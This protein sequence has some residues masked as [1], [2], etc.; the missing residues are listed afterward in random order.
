MEAINKI[1][2]PYIGSD[3]LT[4]LKLISLSSIVGNQINQQKISFLLITD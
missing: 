3:T 1:P 2:F 4:T